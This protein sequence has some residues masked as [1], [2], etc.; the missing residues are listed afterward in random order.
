MS[1]NN[2]LPSLPSIRNLIISLILDI[3]G[4]ASYFI[5]FLG[6]VGDLYYAP[7]YG[8]AIYWMYRQHKPA[9]ILGG[10]IGFIE[11]ILPATDM[12]PTA[13][14]MWF[15]AYWKSKKQ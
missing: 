6:E 9:A 8:A 11:E 4:V 15:Y 2:E 5:P 10:A 7:I 3:F 1:N 14:L 13:T 12:M